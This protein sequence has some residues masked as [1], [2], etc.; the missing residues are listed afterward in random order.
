MMQ[1][2][3]KK[4]NQSAQMPTY[5][6]PWDAG[7]DL[8]ANEDCTIYYN[9]HNTVSTGIAVEI[10]AGYVGLIHPRSGMASKHGITVLNSPGTID[11]GY[12][13]ELKV[14]LV[15]HTGI[16]YEV[17]KGDKIAQLVIQKVEEAQFV[18][19]DELS[20]SDRNDK[21]FGSTGK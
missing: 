4:L 15:N 5:A 19:V 11:A 9:S 3:F 1:I 8:Y 20:N 16:D 12:R 2:K 14:I 10:P 21:G 17:I 13:G 18:E 6:K 7:A